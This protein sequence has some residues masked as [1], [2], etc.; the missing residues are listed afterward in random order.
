MKR[1][2]SIVE[3]TV[4]LL[5]FSM[6]LVVVLNLMTISSQRVT[7]QEQSS[8]CTSEA[9]LV[10]AMLRRDAERMKATDVRTAAEF[11][12]GAL[13]LRTGPGNVTYQWNERERELVRFA[14]GKSQTLAKGLI[15]RFSAV[16]QTLGADGITRSVPPDP[17]AAA[18][19]PALPSPPPRVLRCWVKVFLTLEMGTP[20]KGLMRQEFVF[21][22]FPVQLNR[23]LHSI[24]QQRD[25]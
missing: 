19:E 25:F 20:G 4:V 8:V 11:R 7:Q 9:S 13:I 5:I 15:S 14:E 23:A 21:R 18:P 6:L 12:D 10:I 17:E 16:F 24:W 22:L 3:I 1:G 2:V